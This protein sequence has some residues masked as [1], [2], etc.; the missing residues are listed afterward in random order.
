MIGQADVHQLVEL[1]VFIGNKQISFDD[2]ENK[3][4][5]YY[6]DVHVFKSSVHKEVSLIFA[7]NRQKKGKK[8]LVSMYL[9]PS[10]CHWA[11]DIEADNLLDKATRIWCATLINVI[12]KEKVKCL[13]AD[14]FNTF[15]KEHPDAVYVGH[16]FLSYDCPMLNRHWGAGIPATRVVDTFVL[17]QLYNP[18]YPGGHSLAAWGERLKYKKGELAQVVQ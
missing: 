10:N 3:E 8:H 1:F 4:Q 18:S 7:K 6:G 17:S 2:V 9:N 15:Q 5:Y 13:S 16:N 11:C 12:S 14:E